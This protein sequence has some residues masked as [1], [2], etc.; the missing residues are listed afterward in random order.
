MKTLFTSIH[1]VLFL[2]NGKEWVDFLAIFRRKRGCFG[3]RRI[4]FSVNPVRRL[5]HRVFLTG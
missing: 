1:D 4:N 5:S 3:A 2:F